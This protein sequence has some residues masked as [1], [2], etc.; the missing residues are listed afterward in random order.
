VEQIARI[1]EALEDIGQGRMVILVDDEDRENEGDLVAA[2]DAITPEQIAFILRE[3]RGLMCVAL[4]P[5]RADELGLVPMARTNTAPLGTAFTLSLDHRELGGIGAKARAATI[6]ALVDPKVGPEIFVSPGHVFPLRAR[7]GG[8][9]I[10]AGQTEGSVDL[11]R[12]AGRAPAGVICEVMSPDGTM[13]RLGRLLEFG[14]QHAIK[15]VT[16]ADLIQYRLA[17]EQ[18]VV[19]KGTAKLPTEHGVFEIRSFQNTVSGEVHV[20]L[21]FGELSPNEPTLVRVHRADTVADVFGI[22]GLGSRSRI[23]WSLRKMAAWGR[24]VLLY[25]RQDD[26]HEPLADSVRR[27][28]AQ[29]RGERVEAANAPPMAF[30]DFGVGAQILHELGIRKIQLLSSSPLRHFTGLRGFGLEITERIPMEGDPEEP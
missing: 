25:L 29:A 26:A 20:A 13:S 14:A 11:A 7:P 30:R 8:V 23:A 22:G 19:C 15:V 4:A 24:G 1:E 12:L 9:L 5:E 2:A 17:H 21:T 16:V 6:R 3:A 10:R 28:G 18:L 27:Y